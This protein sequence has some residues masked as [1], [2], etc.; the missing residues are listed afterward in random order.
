MAAV[1]RNTKVDHYGSADRDASAIL[2]SDSS[3]KGAVAHTPLT[4]YSK[5]RPIQQL[6]ADIQRCT[7]V[8]TSNEQKYL[9]VVFQFHLHPQ[10]STACHG[11][12]EQ[13]RTPMATL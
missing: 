2:Y 11:S 6:T 1:A 7:F 12:F 3:L 4:V 9:R 10:V 5:Q 8:T 13:F